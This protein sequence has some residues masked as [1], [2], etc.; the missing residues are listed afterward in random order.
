ML[1]SQRV[2]ELLACPFCRQL[3]TRD[4]AKICPECDLA[5]KPLHELPPSHDADLLDEPILLEEPQ[6]ELLSWAYL[7]RGRGALLLVTL[8]GIAVFFA[9][10]LHET[11]PEIR[12]LS[13]YAFSRLLGWIWAGGIA[14]FVMLPLVASRRTIRQMRGARVAVGFLASMVVLTVITRLSLQPAAHPLIP[15]RYSWGWG[16]YAAGCLGI[17]ALVLAYK[18]GGDVD[19]MPTGR[20]RRGDET[21]H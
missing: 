19:D 14:W 3:Y 2:D 4:D 10:W 1:G 17:A 20:E 9:P 5:V 21:L 11:A 18:F 6:D 15:V 12:T 13:G 16:M 7:G 8:A